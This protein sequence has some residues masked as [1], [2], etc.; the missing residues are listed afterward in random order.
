MQG[1]VL[2]LFITTTNEQKK[3]ECVDSIE[4]DNEGIFKDKFYAK[5]RERSILLTSKESYIMAQ[6]E[7]IK[8]EDGML[9]ENILLDINPYTLDNGAKIFI[10]DIELE[11]TQSCT[12]CKGLSSLNSKLP[13][14]LK[15]DRGVFAKVVSGKGSINIGDNIEF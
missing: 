2:K 13:K 5:N 11:I 10:G 7:G 3:R 1:K 8:I 9:G 6:K 15:D 14:L 12:L 4:L